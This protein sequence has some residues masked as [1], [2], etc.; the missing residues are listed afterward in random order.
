LRPGLFSNDKDDMMSRGCQLWVVAMA[1]VAL[2]ACQAAPTDK[3]YDCTTKEGVAEIARDYSYYVFPALREQMKTW[4][5]QVTE[6][7]VLWKIHYMPRST[8]VLGEFPVL[9]FEKN[10][11]VKAI[12]DPA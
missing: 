6:D 2:S 10:C 3:R 11:H 1:S 4:V 5:M 7:G 12:I 9:V 8:T